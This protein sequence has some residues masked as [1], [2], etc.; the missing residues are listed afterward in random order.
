MVFALQVRQFA[1]QQLTRHRPASGVHPS[2]CLLS[3]A[4]SYLHS[5]D[6]KRARQLREISRP[7][8]ADSFARRQ[9]RPHQ[10]DHARLDPRGLPAA[11]SRI[12]L[13]PTKADLI[14]TSVRS[15]SYANSVAAGGRPACLRLLV[16]Q[17]RGGL[18]CKFNRAMYPM[19]VADRAVSGH[20]H[21]LQ[22][23]A[24]AADCGEESRAQRV[25]RKVLHLQ[26][27]ERAATLVTPR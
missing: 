21:G 22:G 9:Y 8:A 7:A 23:H 11:A 15:A 1:R 25:G 2:A 6:M 5:E 12:A 18:T 17:A 4:S 19:A 20:V 24:A 26:P 16:Q 27:R 10:S 14:L 13:N 3:T